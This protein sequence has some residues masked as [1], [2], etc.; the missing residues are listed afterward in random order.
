MATD[1]YTTAVNQLDQRLAE[2]G[3]IK[4]DFDDYMVKR[5]GDDHA[6][7]KK[8][9]QFIDDVLNRFYGEAD[10]TGVPLPWAKT[11]DT[12]R[13]RKSEVSIWA[14]YNGHGKS[15]VLGQAMVWAAAHGEKVLIAS[16]EMKPAATLARMCR[17]AVG[18]DMPSEQYIRDFHDW[19][20][21]KMWIYDQQGTVTPDRVISVAHWAA[22]KLGITQF[23]IDSLMKCGINED[24][25]NK[26]KK[27]VDQLCAL[28]RDTGMHVHL[29][30]HSRKNQDE[31]EPPN[32]LDI[33]GSGTITD[34]VD[35]VF[36]VHRK[37]RKEM[38]VASG[39]AT[40]E[41]LLYPDAEIICDKQ[42]HGEWEGKVPL[43]YDKKSF[44]YLDS[45][46]EKVWQMKLEPEKK[47]EVQTSDS[48]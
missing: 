47:Q 35:N 23:V 24:D 3:I 10:L 12:I 46:K 38:A 16:F 29:V 14:G 8:A 11:A 30:A 40:P 15:M 26:Q 43:W 9:N 31:F 27:F 32:K 33:R 42:R 2:K 5:D 25:Y 45:P 34:Q 13:L 37:K 28:A 4:V 48:W 6:N 7:V 36:T 44:R 41:Q 21:G 18:S 22:E 19:T 39:K 20:N 1:R 17:Q